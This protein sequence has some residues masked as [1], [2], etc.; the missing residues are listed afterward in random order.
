MSGGVDSSVAA[1]LLREQGY[2]VIGL[3]MLPVAG[4]RH[5]AQDA[6]GIAC[7]LGIEHVT[8]ECEELF[9]KQVIEDFCHAYRNGKTPNP[10]IRCNDT[11]KFGFLLDHAIKLGADLFATGHYAVVQRSDTSGLFQL[12]S[13]KD[14]KKDQSYFLYRLDQ[15]RLSRIIMPLGRLTKQAVKQ[16][17]RAKGLPIRSDCESQDICF[18]AGRDYAELVC[19]LFPEAAQPGPFLTSDGKVVGTHRGLVYYTVGQRRGIGIAARTPLYVL[20]LDPL[21]NAVVIGQRENLYQAMFTARDVHWVAGEAPAQPVRAIAKIRYLHRAAPAIIEARDGL[22]VAVKFD[23]PQMS[24]TPGQ[25]AVF[26][27]PVDSSVLGGGII[28]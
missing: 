11:V 10:C 17:A 23:E 21:R 12:L 1:Y 7:S 6:R 14:K 28:E 20:A 26:Y 9:H 3:T 15:K 25:S 19:K 5:V 18:L 16:L 4:M 8:I 27:D 22:R 13:S 24:I 2:R